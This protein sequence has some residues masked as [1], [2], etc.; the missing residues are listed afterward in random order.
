MGVC[1]CMRER[2]REGRRGE[3]ERKSN[4]QHF[5]D[6]QMPTL[7]YACNNNFFF[8]LL[9]ERRVVNVQKCIKFR[10]EPS[11]PPSRRKGA[12]KQYFSFIKYL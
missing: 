5:N 2:E 4:V 10:E 1:V 8:F 7:Q 12:N 9:N 6:I 3:R 11:P